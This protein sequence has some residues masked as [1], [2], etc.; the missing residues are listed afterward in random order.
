MTKTMAQNPIA[1]IGAGIAG[2]TAA[3]YLHQ[4][5]VPFV[6]YEAGK[7]IAG[8]ASSFKDDEGF[9]YD[10]GAHFVTNRLAAMLGVSSDCKPVKYYSET[11]LLGGKTYAYP[12]GLMKIPRM[13]LSGIRSQI[14]ADGTEKTAQNW[15]RGKY[16]K[17]LADEVALPLIEAWSGAKAEDLSSSVGESLPGS[18]AKTIYLK[19]A[20]KVLKRAVCIGYSRELPESP[21]VWHVYPNEGVHTLCEKLAENIQD[22][23][24]LNSPIEEVLVENEKVVAVRSKGVTQAVSAVISTTPA[25][26]L[27]KITKGTNKLDK[28][29]K[30]KYRPM[31]FVNMRFEGRG[32]LPDVVLWLPENKY[33]FFRLTEATLSM[34][35]LA[36][37]GKTMITV[38][39]GCE[40]DDEIWTMENEKLGEFCL[41]H[42]AK[43]IPNAKEKY[44]GCH[45]LRTP[46]S[47]PVFLK[48][49]EQERLEF[50]KGTG[51]ENLL[52][53]GRNGEFAHIFMEDVYW[54]TLQKTRELVKLLS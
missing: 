6:L 37:E 5:N 1:I 3:N 13:T 49:Y 11:V 15:F 35:W 16:G 4:K 36:P 43:I 39:I 50:E 40:K 48:E 17:A 38:D 47:Y 53:V 31:T 54:R 30:F 24:K 29:S 26:I 21:N 46:I 20:S 22:K 23:I 45:T 12:F 2:L 19:L 18:I 52:S 8:L 10:F 9:S 51:I 7:K 25:P 14:S 32:L 42:L 28:F 41:E 33:P 34:P 27:A 44:L